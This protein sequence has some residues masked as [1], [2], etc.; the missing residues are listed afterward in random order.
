MTIIVK[1]GRYY[2]GIQGVFVKKFGSITIFVSAL[3]FLEDAILVGLGRY[4][5]VNFFI[6]LLGT[7]IFGVLIAMMA[8]IPK[9]KKWLGTD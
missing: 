3:H 4:T 7:I 2:K 1:S 6:L 5:E 8:R 9:V